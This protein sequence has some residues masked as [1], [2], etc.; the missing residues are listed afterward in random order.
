M[1]ILL[2]N[3]ASGVVVSAGGFQAL[4]RETIAA[5]TVT[6]TLTDEDTDGDLDD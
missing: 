1:L 4:H 5:S 6:T 2:L 3:G